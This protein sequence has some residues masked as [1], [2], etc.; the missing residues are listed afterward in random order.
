MSRK[1]NAFSIDAILGQPS[2]VRCDIAKAQT[3][4][5]NEVPTSPPQADSP[6]GKF[7]AF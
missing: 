4:R 6:P 7:Y 3:T 5:A 1:A 2:P